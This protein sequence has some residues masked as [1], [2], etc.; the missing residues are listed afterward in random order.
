[1]EGLGDG[2]DVIVVEAAMQV[3]RPHWRPV[4]AVL[5]L[6]MTQNIETVGQMSC[7]PAIGGIGKKPSCQRLM[8]WVARW[9]C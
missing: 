4:G 1:M 3:L 6:L 7:N 5:P 8:H 2:F 9:R